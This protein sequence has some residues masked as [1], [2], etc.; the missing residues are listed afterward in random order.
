MP[1]LLEENE[2]LNEKVRQM[3]SDQS[4]IDFYLKFMEGGR[5]TKKILIE[6]M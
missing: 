5:D 4:V 3:E 6:Y 2:K 1:K